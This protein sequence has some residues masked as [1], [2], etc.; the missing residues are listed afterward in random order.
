MATTVFTNGSVGNREDLED[1]ITNIAPKETPF[2]SSMPKVQ[3][4][5]TYHEWLTDTLNTAT[6]NKNTENK[7]WT[8][9]TSN[10]RVRT[11]DYTQIFYKGVEVTYTQEQVNKAGLTSEKAY[12]QNLR[13]AELARDIEYALING[14]GASGATGTERE[15]VGVEA[16]IQTNETTGTALTEDLL[17]DN[18]ELIWNEGGQ[19]KDCYCN[20]T[21]KRV[22]DSFKLASQR[23]VTATTTVNNVVD[24]YE[25]SFGTIKI[26][27][28]RY[29][30]S[31]KVYN[32]DMSKFAIGVLQRVQAQEMPIAGLTHRSQIFGE[33]T[34]ISRQEAGSGK[35]TIA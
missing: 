8:A 21:L 18:L 20:A 35:I 2:Y 28:D 29:V 30:A 25:S 24:I 16:W 12:Q 14:T 13:L 10:A 17:N 23:Y 33:L 4:N 6:A 19:A 5:S 27:L 3:I 11:G 15:L 22:I 26:I 31:G 34:L 1:V 9:T 7:A 32:M